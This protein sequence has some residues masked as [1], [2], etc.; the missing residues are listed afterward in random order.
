LWIRG[1]VTGSIVTPQSIRARRIPSKVLRRN[2]GVRLLQHFL[3]YSDPSPLIGENRA[4]SI[5]ESI[6][7]L[8]GF[9]SRE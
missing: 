5:N 4:G 8:A 9:A 3:A 6:Q 1:E 7:E 2:N